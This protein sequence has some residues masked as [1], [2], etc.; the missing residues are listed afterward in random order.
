MEK[1]RNCVVETA[2]SARLEG[3]RKS[4]KLC[5]LSHLY[6]DTAPPICVSKWSVHGYRLP[7]TNDWCTYCYHTF[8]FE[9]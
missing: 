5:R 3:L 4:I 7:S 8:S 1:T 6:S 9:L 2:P